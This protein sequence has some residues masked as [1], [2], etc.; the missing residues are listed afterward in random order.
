[1]KTKGINAGLSRRDLFKLG[2][3]AAVGVA[4]L[5]TLSACSP[6]GGSATADA[7]SKT[8]SSLDPAVSGHY[9]EVLPSFLA[10][11]EPIAE[12]DIVETKEYDVVVVGA[13]AAGVTCALS[14]VEN[15]A[16]V[17]VLQKEAKVVSQGNT[18]T[19]IDLTASG[20]GAAG[21]VLGL[22]LKGNAYRSNPELN[23]VW[24]ENSGEAVSWVIER[25]AEAG[26]Q[27]SNI[28]NRMAAPVSVVNDIPITYVTSEF[29]PKPY[30]AGDG[31]AVLAT[32]AESK[33]AEFFFN[34]PGQQLVKDG[35][36]VV[37]VIGK[38]PDGYIK[39][40]GTKGIILATGDFQN[41]TAMS[42]YY[43]PDLKHFTRKQMNK[44][45]DGHKMGIWAGA[46]MENLGH[47]K[48]LHDFDG[49]PASMCD[50]P[51]LNVNMEGKR[52]ANETCEMADQA[53][54]LKQEENTGYYAQLFDSSYQEK[55]AGWPGVLQ[56]P[57]ALATWMPEESVE[58]KGVFEDLI[59]TYKADTLEELAKKIDVPA[60]ELKKTVERYNELS[61]KGID[62][63]FGKPAKF[64]TTSLT[65]PPFYAMKRWLRVTATFSG[66]NVNTESAV[67]DANGSPI[68]GLYAIGNVAGNYYGGVDYPMTIPG[69][70]LGRCY[71]FGYVVGRAV[72]TK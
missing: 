48:C 72:A 2:G 16:T 20:E 29:G 17:A 61:E 30:T 55:A 53:N 35:D 34:T 11:P 58:R 65:T 43:L 28:G 71:T 33:G 36:A 8:A 51:F 69:Q 27:V 49:G 42:D 67:L 52:Y 54:F 23:R 22:L 64:M 44:T 40:V 62:L 56:T 45:G 1:M 26:A 5:S 31:M 66:L 19:G 41:D 46:T 12:S 7:S 3:V 37:A 39:F 68:E 21:A 4:G 24:T 14:A 18:G 25:A 6:Q 50:M 59:S 63:D 47:T 70:S 15:G 9:A 60:D 13:G 32:V 57:E 10:E 38:G